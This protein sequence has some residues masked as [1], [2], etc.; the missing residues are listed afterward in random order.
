MIPAYNGVRWLPQTLAAA[1]GQT[2]RNIRVLVSDDGSTDGTPELVASVAASDPRVRMIS[3]S[4]R[5]R[6]VGNS[7]HLIDNV[8]GDYA[9]FL[10]QD[11]LIVDDSVATLLR[12]LRS[13]EGP[14]VAYGDAV[15]FSERGLEPAWRSMMMHRAGGPVARCLSVIAERHWAVALRGLA[16]VALLK[17]TPRL[18]VH[19]AGEYGADGPW[20]AALALRAAFIRVPEVLYYKRSHDTGVTADWRHSASTASS[21]TR[22][23]MEM[24]SEMPLNWWEIVAIRTALAA[25]LGVVKLGL[26]KSIFARSGSLDRVEPGQPVLRRSR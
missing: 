18:R 15:P 11:D 10:M 21:L 19:D 9:C 14:A 7:N 16:P 4:G 17:A 20:V 5:R 25:R 23:Y 24:I 6:W 3:T 22:S 26:R 2:H 12:A 1:T 8:E 13:H